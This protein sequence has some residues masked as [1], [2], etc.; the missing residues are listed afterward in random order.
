MEL[1]FIVLKNTI[2]QTKKDPCPVCNNSDYVALFTFDKNWNGLS[3]TAR[4]SCYGKN[5]EPIEMFDV[6]IIDG[7]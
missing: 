4:F 5:K 2:Y 3:K 7:K 1:K 6:P